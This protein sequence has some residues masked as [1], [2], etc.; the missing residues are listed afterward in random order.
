[1]CIVK[2]L[3]LVH[4][5]PTR[6][7]TLK[8]QETECLGECID[9]EKCQPFNLCQVNKE[10]SWYLFAEEDG[11]Y[12]E[13]R[14]CSF[15]STKEAVVKTGL[16]LNYYKIKLNSKCVK[17][18][19][20]HALIIKPLT[21]GFP[22]AVLYLTNNNYLKLRDSDG[23]H[24]VTGESSIVYDDNDDRCTEFE[25]QNL[26]TTAQTNFQQHKQ[27]FRQDYHQLC[28]NI[29]GVTYPTMIPYQGWLF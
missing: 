19:T 13:R 25:I 21:T 20:N 2:N 18:D 10:L 5:K 23:C 24:I 6:I 29:Y 8:S 11:K 22:C 14:S 15:F 28:S 9:E 17:S 27:I 3:E 12:N 4:V 1:M 16:L 7:V 26:S